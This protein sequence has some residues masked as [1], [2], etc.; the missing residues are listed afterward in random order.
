M[1]SSPASRILHLPEENPSESVNIPRLSL[2]P[3]TNSVAESVQM[4][5]ELVELKSGLQLMI[6]FINQ[7]SQSKNVLIE[8][9]I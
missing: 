1:F 5:M 9:P 3:L 4:E 2:S 6:H 8:K 7:G